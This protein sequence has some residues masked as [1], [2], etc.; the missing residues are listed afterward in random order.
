MTWKASKKKVASVEVVNDSGG[1]SLLGKVYGDGEFNAAAVY[2]REKNGVKWKEV[3]KFD[4][5]VSQPV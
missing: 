1:T 3:M 4:R 5:R 2:E